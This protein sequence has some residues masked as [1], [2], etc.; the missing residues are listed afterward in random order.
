MVAVESVLP[1][2]PS[3]IW[4]FVFGTLHASRNLPAREVGTHF[5][6]CA[7]MTTAE[8][9]LA[10]LVLAI[11]PASIVVVGCCLSLLPRTFFVEVLSILAI[12]LS[13]SLPVGVV[14]GHFALSEGDYR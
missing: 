11:V 2:T 6:G 7:C 14:V 9:R 5:G 4:F 12:W 13:F 8:D 1:A 3:C 10:R